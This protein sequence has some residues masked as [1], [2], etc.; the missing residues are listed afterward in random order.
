M[1]VF[2]D[3]TKRVSRAAASVSAGGA[4]TTV[5]KAAVGMYAPKYYG[6]ATKLA[7][8]DFAGAAIS[9]VKANLPSIHNPALS[10]LLLGTL[11]NPLLGGITMSEAQRIHAQVQATQYAKKNL[12]FIEIL[13]FL[14]DRGGA[15]QTG[16]NPFNLFATGVSFGPHTIT[17]EARPFGSA[18]ADGVTGS[19]RVELRLTTYDD[20]HGTL[21]RWFRN[22][23][24][25]IT[26]SD[27]TFGV[28]ADYLVQ[29][30]VLHAAI[31]D[32]VMK[33]FGGYEQKFIMR[34]TSMECEL[35]RSEDNL[36]EV[37]MAF[38]QFDTFMYQEP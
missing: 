17:S 5:G 14:P 22:R 16:F 8:G 9:A 26:H 33:R 10:Q 30:R 6:A 7:N 2:D 38:S 21:K 11:R 36:E 28:P 25:A 13:D 31:N 12:F 20:A 23:I 4:L 32:D 18:V 34:P 29:I 19:E 3:V 24:E 37:Q 1:G 35:S 27:G 15:Q